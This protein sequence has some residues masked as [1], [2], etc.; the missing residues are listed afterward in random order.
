MVSHYL[1]HSHKFLC[2]EIR[3]S[4]FAKSAIIVPN[5]PAD[6][7]KSLLLGKTSADGDGVDIGQPQ[8]D[9]GLDFIGWGFWWLGVVEDKT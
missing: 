6:Y 9:A 1:C 4:S 2:A 3:L 8:G 5:K 7:Y